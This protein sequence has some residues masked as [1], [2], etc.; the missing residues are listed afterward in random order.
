MECTDKIHFFATDVLPAP[1]EEFTYPF[2]YT[3]HPLTELAAQ[4]VERYLE[5]Q[6]EWQEELKKGKMFGVL[7]VRTPEGKTGYLAAFSGNLAGQNLHDFFV[8]PVYDLLCPD[9]VFRKGEQRISDINT[10][11]RQMEASDEYRIC[12]RQVEEVQASATAQLA[13]AKQ[14][15]KE[16]K[17]I[18]QAKR[19]TV[20]DEAELEA[21]VRESQF[22]KAELK[23]LERRLKQEVEE[24]KTALNNIE[25]TIAALK[26]ERKK[27]SAE[28]QRW[29]FG[30]FQMLN[31]NGEK[32]DLCEIFKDTPQGTP[33]A[34]AGECALPKLL[35]YAYQNHLYPL[36]MGEFW[37]GMSPKD[38]IRHHGHF[39]PSCKGKC[40]PILKHML[41]GLKV[42]K[43]PL[44]EN[45]HSQ[46][47]L[48]IVY[49]D[50]WIIVVNKPAG[51]LSVPGKNDLDSVSQRL[52]EYLT[53]ATGPLIVHRLDMA[54]SGLLLAAKSKEIH[55]QLQALF[56]TRNIR[57]RYIAILDGIL[58]L[59]EGVIDLP[60]CLNPLDRPR[61]MVDYTYGKPAITRYKVNKRENGKTYVDFFPQ[62]GRTHQ[63]RVHSAH[64]LGLNCPITG[65]ELYGR[66]STRLYLHAAELSFVHPVTGKLLTIQK[67]ADFPPFPSGDFSS[68][69]P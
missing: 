38:E 13:A 20:L 4:E 64:P 31:A 48:D 18:R 3:P 67:E 25:Q 22:Q 60:L 69:L 59:D 28:L 40:E 52:S 24:K 12:R 58:P 46:T 37:W 55:Q 45:I 56:E 51:M 47:P 6:S 16:A 54:T 14:A 17:A 21:L 68:Q 33:P 49:E 53:H 43:N 27:S 19:N 35:Q 62:T 23:R 61:Q 2:H 36:A 10:R 5:T 44:D 32:K 8:P 65:D 34:G 42:E 30:R 63:L 11:I 1:P 9:G 29:I 15:L 39:Y 26:E 50:E 66:K 7:I 57:K 41:V